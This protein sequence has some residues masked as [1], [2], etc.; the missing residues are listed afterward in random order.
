MAKED[1][2]GITV[3]KSDNFSEWY[4]QLVGEQGAQLADVRYGVQGFVVYREWGYALL[5]KVYELLE[6][7]AENDDHN[8]FLFP[9]VIPEENLKKEEEHAGFTP[10]VFWVTKAG[11]EKLEKPLALRPTGETQIYPMYSL[12]IRSYKDLPYKAY[13][14]RIM[15]Y[16]NE[17]TTRPFIRGR[18]F[19]FFETHDVF[20]THK[21]S[22]DQVK[23]DM[24]MMKQVAY[25][26]LF[27]PFYFFKRPVWDKFLG[28]DA[29]YSSDT[30]MPDGKRNQ[31]SSTHDLG[32]NFAKPFN[33]TYTD[34]K[35]KEQFAYQTCWGPGIIRLVAALISIHG[36]DNGLVLPSIIA[37]VKVVIIPVYFSDKKAVNEKIRKKCSQLKEEIKKLG[38]K[39]KFDDLDESP[40]YKYNK[41]ELK[42]V[43]LRIELGPREVDQNKVTIVTRVDRKKS[44]ID[45]KNLKKEIE[46]SLKHN[47]EQIKK[48][49]DAYFKGNTKS[50]DTLEEVKK[51]IEEHRG[52]IKAP[53]CSVEKDGEECADTLKAETRGGNVCG[54]PLEK[55]ETPKNKKCVVCKKKAK[56]IVYIAKS[57]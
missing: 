5:R 19:C 35:G 10:E 42:G 31:I 22:L 45:L 49:A 56:H 21:E 32:H 2:I 27:I 57:Y 4:S 13:Q 16:R 38:Y 15:C 12:W 7:V 34:E 8:Q 9:I 20:A 18:E 36:D 39:V 53:F 1:K 24:Q 37:P 52:F 29:T 26:Q 46:N 54:T 50:A 33:V 23:K 6:E 44:Q 48:R 55:P 14:S 43:P 28:A 51:I 30:I 40:G 17:M 25:D 11:N 47:D 41:W 3:K